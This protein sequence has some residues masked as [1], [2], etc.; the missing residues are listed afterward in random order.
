[1]EL[2]DYMRSQFLEPLQRDIRRKVVQVAADRG[3]AKTQ[4]RRAKSDGE[5]IDEATDAIHKE[6]VESPDQPTAVQMN[7]FDLNE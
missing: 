2:N 1:M 7:L 4:R 6:P 5:P 3:V